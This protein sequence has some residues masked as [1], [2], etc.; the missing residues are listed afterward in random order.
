MTR[1]TTGALGEKL[2]AD[3]L[4]KR[5]FK[6]METNFRCK[7]GEADIVALDGDCLV[8]VEVRT[9]TSSNFGSPEESITETKQEHLRATAGRYRESRQNLPESTRIDLVAVELDKS[10]NLRR[11]ELLQNVVEGE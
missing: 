6:I 10:G 2:A 5:G 4:T 1:Q 8:I 3:F 11:V 9:K 7:E